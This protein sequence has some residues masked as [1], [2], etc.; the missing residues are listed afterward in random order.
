MPKSIDKN[1]VDISKLFQWGQKFNLKDRFGKE[2]LD[3]YVR[4]IGD[5]ELNRSRVYALRSSAQL[6][7]KLK[8]EN[9]DERVAYIPHPSTMTKDELIN[10]LVLF[11]NKALTLKAFADIK[12]NLPVEPDSD[13]SLEEREKYQEAVDNFPIKR[14]EEIR[15]FVQKE[16]DV[17]KERLSKI[18]VEKLYSEYEKFLIDQ[19]CEGHMID[20]FREACAFYG[21][22]KDEEYKERLLDSMEDF[23][24]IPTEIK[25]QLIQFYLVLEIGGE[26]LKKLQEAML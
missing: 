23:E 19:V 12:A 20:K 9:S 10:A 15:E 22:Y 4:L 26:D 13:A 18:K 17:E 8:D 16:I 3:V 5:A 1:D 7:L 21:T 2:V 14:E 25:N 6:R 11:H 24:N